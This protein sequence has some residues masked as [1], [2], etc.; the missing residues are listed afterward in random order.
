MRRLKIKNVEYYEVTDSSGEKM[1]LDKEKSGPIYF[2]GCIDYCIQNKLGELEYDQNDDCIF[3]LILEETIIKH[4]KEWIFEVLGIEDQII[5]DPKNKW[6]KL[7]G[8]C[9]KGSLKY[10]YLSYKGKFDVYT[11]LRYFY[12]VS[13]MMENP[14]ID[15]YIELHKSMKNN[16]N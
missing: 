12:S 6:K 13:S 14:W 3:S 8:T 11:I 15:R 2:R 9:S 10:D 1:M 4:F 7:C 5:L 16:I